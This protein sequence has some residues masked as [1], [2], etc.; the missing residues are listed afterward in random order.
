MK[1]K[2][3]VRHLQQKVKSIAEDLNIDLEDFVEANPA[4]TLWSSGNVLVELMARIREEEMK[5]IHDID[6]DFIPPNIEPMDNSLDYELALQESRPFNKRVTLPS[7]K[8]DDPFDQ[9][10]SGSEVF[11]EVMDEEELS[12]DRVKRASSQI[13]KSQRKQKAQKDSLERQ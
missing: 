2:T 10:D 1:A 8:D 12:R 3:G 11:N 4:A 9:N 5:Y 7:A 13:I 6:A